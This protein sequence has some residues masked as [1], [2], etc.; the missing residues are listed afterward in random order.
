M[1]VNLKVRRAPHCN[2]KSPAL[3]KSTTRPTQPNRIQIR[4]QCLLRY[5]KQFLIFRTGTLEIR[6]YQKSKITS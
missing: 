5:I 6:L 1:R 3:R 4:R 2:F